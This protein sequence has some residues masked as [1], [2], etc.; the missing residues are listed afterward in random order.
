MAEKLTI[1]LTDCRPVTI[2]KADWPVVASSRDWDGEHEFQ[3]FRK[4]RLTVRQHADGRCIVY[5][6]HDTAW[7]NDA[8]R[9]GGE[10][11]ADL[12]AAP[13]AIVRVAESMNFPQAV[14]ERCVAD[15]PA[16]EL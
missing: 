3:A 12:D 7:P 1:T 4:W 15:L 5:G 8:D 13:A 11:V 10:I 2:D 6:V 14:T 16:V 9:R